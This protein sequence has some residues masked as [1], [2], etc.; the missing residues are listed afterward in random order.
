MTTESPS[1]FSRILSNEI[2][3][4]GVAGAVGAVLVAAVSELLW[5]SA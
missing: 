4:K 2:A 3:R 5:P 1:F